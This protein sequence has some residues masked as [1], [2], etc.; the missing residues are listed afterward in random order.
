M[1]GVIIKCYKYEGVL[2]SP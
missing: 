1:H 2:I